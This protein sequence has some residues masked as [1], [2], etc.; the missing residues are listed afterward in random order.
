MD[1]KTVSINAGGLYVRGLVVSS[2]ANAFQRKDGSGT[3]VKVQHELATQPGVVLFEQYLSPKESPDV[4]VEDGKVTAYPRLDQFK[5]LTL[6]VV[7][8]RIANDQLV[9]TQAEEVKEA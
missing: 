1:R 9:V 6:R 5:E 8:Y 7:R 4:K 3:V 2:S